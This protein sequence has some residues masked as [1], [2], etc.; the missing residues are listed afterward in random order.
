M[1]DDFD[2]KAR[3]IAKYVRDELFNSGVVTLDE[4]RSLVAAENSNA[5]EFSCAACHAPITDPA[6]KSCSKCGSKTMVISS[7]RAYRCQRC[8]SPVELSDPRCG[9]CGHDKAVPASVKSN[10]AP[11]YTCSSCLRTVS[12]SQPNCSCGNRKAYKTF[13][14]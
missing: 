14:R 7:D 6:A 5:T 3:A 1:A 13:E 12:L 11:Y 8:G 9:N 10:P 4:A 2:S